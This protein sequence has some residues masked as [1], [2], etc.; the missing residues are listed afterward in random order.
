MKGKVFRSEAAHCLA[1]T[2]ASR[3]CEIE[4]FTTYYVTTSYMIA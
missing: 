4:L 3:K 2:K 1:P